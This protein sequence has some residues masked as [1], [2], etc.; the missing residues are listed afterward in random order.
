MNDVSR[1]QKV[2]LQLTVDV[3]LDLVSVASK[4]G[5]QKCKIGWPKNFR[6]QGDLCDKFCLACQLLCRTNYGSRS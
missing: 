1:L 3:D 4:L 2:M 6:K 5:T